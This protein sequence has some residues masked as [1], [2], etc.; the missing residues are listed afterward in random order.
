MDVPFLDQMIAK[1]S[2][3]QILEFVRN[4]ICDLNN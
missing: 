4:V 2:E 1:P 3:G